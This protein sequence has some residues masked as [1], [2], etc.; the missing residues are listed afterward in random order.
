MSR[1]VLD[2]VSS[3]MIS[4]CFYIIWPQYLHT[5]VLIVREL[6]NELRAV[7]NAISSHYDFTRA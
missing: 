4:T 7:Q 3:H 1:A 5:F 6:R 2:I